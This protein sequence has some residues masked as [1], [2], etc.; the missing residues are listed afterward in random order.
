MAHPSRRVF[1]DELTERLDRDAEVVWDRKGDEWDT[2]S[3]ALLAFDPDATH[4]LVIQDD[5]IPCQD[6]VAGTERAAEL[7]HGHPLGLYVGRVRPNYQV[8]GAAVDRGKRD[9]AT[10]LAME[11][12]WWG[13]ALAIPTAHIR[14]LVRW[15]DEHPEPWNTGLH[16]VLEYDKRIAKWYLAQKLLCWYTLPSLV[17]H[18]PEAEN[19][20]LLPFHRGDRRAHWFIGEDK[21]ALDIDWAGRGIK[22][23]M[24]APLLNRRR[25][26][27]WI[28]TPVPTGRPAGLE[29]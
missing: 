1:V 29:A 2:G 27:P 24:T 22:H 11:G 10:W 20:T 12:P 13:V 4:H 3:R 25:P 26:T 15:V 21:S 19:P 18:R 23:G 16:R 5:A 17:D 7:T 8:V 14:E 28:N 6:L 9:G